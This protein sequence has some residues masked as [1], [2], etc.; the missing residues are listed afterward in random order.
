MPCPFGH[1]ILLS[2]SGRGEVDADWANGAEAVP[3][4]CERDASFKEQKTHKMKKTGTSA[5][6]QLY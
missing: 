4:Y 6:F 3:S 1:A 5:R 2:L